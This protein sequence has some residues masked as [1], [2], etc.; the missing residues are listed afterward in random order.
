MS[1]C[2]PAKTTADL[3]IK[4]EKAKPKSRKANATIFRSLVRA[5]LFLAEQTRPDFMW[6]INI[7][8]L[9]MSEPTTDHWSARKRVLRYF[10][11]FRRF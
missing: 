3:N 7:L 10:K 2:T 8:S 9:F 1:D 4:L 11:S 6:I 5:L